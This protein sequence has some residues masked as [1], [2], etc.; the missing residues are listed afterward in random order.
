MEFTQ[1]LN[2]LNLYPQLEMN[3][4]L[5]NKFEGTMNEF[6]EIFAG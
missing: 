5:N 6:A 2:F 1:M 4:I 3:F